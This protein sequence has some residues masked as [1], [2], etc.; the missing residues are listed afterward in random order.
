MLDNSQ[1]ENAIE[2]PIRV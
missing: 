2:P 1:Y